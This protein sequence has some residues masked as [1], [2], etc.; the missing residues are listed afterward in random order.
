MRHNL[1]FFSELTR[2]KP[3]PPG[4][5]TTENVVVPEI[6]MATRRLSVERLH[7]RRVGYWLLALGLAAIV[8]SRLP[9][10]FYGDELNVDESMQMA[11][12]RR[13]EMDWTLWRGADYTTSG[14]LN[15]GILAVLHSLGVP[16]T[17]E[18]VHG[19]AVM[20]LIAILLIASRVAVVFFGYIPGTLAFFGAALWI[21]ISLTDDFIHYSSELVPGFLIAC[22][23]AVLAG[24]RG[25][26]TNSYLKLVSAGIVLGCAPWAK[27]QAAPIAFSVCVWVACSLFVHWVVKRELPWAAFLRVGTFIVAALAPTILVVL[28]CYQAGSLEYAWRSYIL[29]NLNYAGSISIRST[30]THFSEILRAPFAV[31]CVC[32]LA[33]A[34]ILKPDCTFERGHASR[35]GLLMLLTVATFI[36]ILRSQTHFRHYEIFLLCPIVL[37]VA[38]ALQVIHGTLGGFSQNLHSKL[39]IALTV[40]AIGSP[41]LSNATSA[42]K[43]YRFSL[44]RKLGDSF[45]ERSLTTGLGEL[46]PPG[47]S[48]YVWG[49][50]PSLY[51]HLDANPATRYML[52]AFLIGPTEFA[53]FARRKLVEDLNQEQPDWIIVTEHTRY[54]DLGATPPF[55]D[56]QAI[57]ADSYTLEMQTSDLRVYGKKSGTRSAR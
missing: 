20:L 51:I 5:R 26:C 40:T 7:N 42:L 4:M 18:T 43:E 38:R 24:S 30:Y 11:L 44:K 15:A 28:L 56:L 14:P 45:S 41:L 35:T 16:L 2:V 52:N 53:E 54:L 34:I 47:A 25:H 21:A 9:S 29:A 55:P 19:V 37:I 39:F 27:L 12:A 8:T 31:G 6:T 49:W 33:I 50:R 10:L 23:L 3:D 57:L 1:E 48:L 36:A 17:Y 46:I 13:M 32:F 22:G